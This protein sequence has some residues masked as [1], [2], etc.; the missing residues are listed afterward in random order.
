MTARD[1]KRS[2]RFRP[3]PTG[4]IENDPPSRLVV[5]LVC[6]QKL[7]KWFDPF[8]LPE[9]CSSLAG[10]SSVVATPILDRAGQVIA[11]LYGETETGVAAGEAPRLPAGCE[12]DRG[13]GVGLSAGLARLEQQRAALSFQ[14]QFEQFFTPELARQLLRRPE[15]L[16]GQDLEITVLFCDIRGFSR[17]IAQARPGDH[18]RVDQRRALDAFRLRHKARGRSGRLHRRRIDGDVGRSRRPARPSRAGLPGRPRDDRV[19]CRP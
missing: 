17:I 2:P 9:D 18:P 12:V 7:T 8:Q 10:V 5:N 13:A 15:L 11:I 19:A 14:T 3:R 16:K 6:E 1:G 4:S